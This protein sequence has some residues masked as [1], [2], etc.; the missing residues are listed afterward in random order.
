M[1]LPSA[2]RRP[3]LDELMS[4][5]GQAS[6]ASAPE[7]EMEQA[8][9]GLRGLVI[10]NE[11]LVDEVLAAYE[12]L[13]LVFDVTQS[14]A[15]VTDAAECE[16][17]LLGHVCTLLKCQAS[18][19]IE[20]EQPPRWY[21]PSRRNPGAASVPP[22]PGLDSLAELI[23]EQISRTRTDRRI[24]V[25]RQGDYHIMS[26]P[27]S[28]LDD[29]IN[30]VL[31]FRAADAPSFL[32]SDLLMFETALSFGSRVLANAEANARLRRMSLE[33]IRA[34]VN[35]IDKKDHYTC[36]HSERVSQF[37]QATG[38]A[39]GLATQ[40][41]ET[42]EWA[43]LLHD[44]GKIG[45][46]EAILCKP[47]RLTNE[48]F[49][50]IK[51]HPRMGYE[52]LCPI[53]SFDRVLEAV[54]YHHEQPDGAG[55]PEGRKGDEVPLLARIVHVVDVYDALTSSRS[56]RPAFPI[57]QALD[58]LKKDSG[59]K[60]DADVVRAFLSIIPEAAETPPADPRGGAA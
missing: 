39:M 52:I 5:L 54:L 58:I 55:Y 50:I 25:M 38:A 22:A 23:A 42:L 16:R 10:E 24:D 27:L 34:L 53:A 15:G 20:D 57:S 14:L 37:A 7:R 1:K 31:A 11:G 13:N 18:C 60:L 36:G 2:N 12:N 43:G 48:E 28:R 17:V 6:G 32:S 35:A 19:V 56:Y 21:D 26:G 40:E 33:V 41:I 8:L 49:D 4:V 59:A 30:T 51:Q 47:G 3:W 45:I 44:V 29:R 9:E 46:P